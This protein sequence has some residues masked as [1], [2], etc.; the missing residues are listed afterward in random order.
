MGLKTQT[1]N[2]AKINATTNNVKSVA[3]LCTEHLDNMCELEATYKGTMPTKY[4]EDIL[5]ALVV[6]QG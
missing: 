3:A 1:V 5:N 6:K 4:R 2:T